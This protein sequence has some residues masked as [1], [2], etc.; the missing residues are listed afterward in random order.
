MV[1]FERYFLFFARPVLRY[2]RSQTPVLFQG[3][4]GV[5]P[6]SEAMFELLVSWTK[7]QASYMG[8][9]GVDGGQVRS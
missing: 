3:A 7:L 1:L 9:E 2:S 5:A 4:W 8:G 6:A